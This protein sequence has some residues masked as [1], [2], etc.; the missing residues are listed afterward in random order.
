MS[1]VGRFGSPECPSVQ[2]P[3]ETADPVVHCRTT[4]S[5]G[6]VTLKVDE[7]DGRDISARASTNSE[8]NRFRPIAQRRTYSRHTDSVTPTVSTVRP[9]H[10]VSRAGNVRFLKII[11]TLQRFVASGDL[12]VRERFIVRT[13]YKYVRQLTSVI[14][15]SPVI[16]V[17]VDKLVIDGFS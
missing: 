16:N 15:I 6:F 17:Y 4:T 14:N 13:L 5:R 1:G 11:Q 2:V 12:S 10:L 9:V 7:N 8:A 3:S